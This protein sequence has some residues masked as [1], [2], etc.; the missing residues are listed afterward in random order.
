VI[1][2][3]GDLRPWFHERLD[4]ALGRGRVDAQPETRAYLVELLAMVGIGR[5]GAPGDV[6]LALQL[7]DARE[8][9]GFERLQRYRA[10]GDEA[11]V[12]NGFFGDHLERRGVSASYVCAVGGSAYESAGTLAQASLSEA[13]R[14]PVYRELASKFARF[15]E[16]L[17]EVRESTVLRT[18]QDIVR[19]YDKWRRTG[20]SKAA[21]RLGEEGVFPTAPTGQV[22]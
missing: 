2:T 1:E 15:C 10:L 13:V 3:F 12:L 16:V 5:R 4:D 17:D 9:S 8:A 11:L 21:E 18:P 20:S 22:H 14:I 6:P 7:R 19:L